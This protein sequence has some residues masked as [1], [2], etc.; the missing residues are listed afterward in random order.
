MSLLYPRLLAG[1]A[2]PLYRE[3]LNLSIAE[4][5]E[6]TG[7]N[8]ESAVYVAVGGDR[9]SEQKLDDLRK[10]V[11][12]LAVEAGYPNKPDLRAQTAF[13]QRIAIALHSEAGL[14]PAE[15][16]SGDAWSFLALIVMPDI[17]FWRYPNPPKERI[18]ASDITRHVFGRLWWRAQLVHSPGDQNPYSALQVLGEAAFDQIYARRAALGGSPYL[19]KAILRVWNGIELRGLSSRR[20]LID[21]LMRLLR[22]APFL[23]FETL[24]EPTLD[25]EL[26]MAAKESVMAIMENSGLSSEKIAEKVDFAFQEVRIF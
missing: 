11:M 12:D 19:V 6:R 20:V 16:S 3:Y 5:S 26:R 21:F 17:A 22:L 9:V 15:A 8:H 18:L 25:N 2:R 24:D 1:Q 14:T 4:L 23:H 7:T 10:I 13:D